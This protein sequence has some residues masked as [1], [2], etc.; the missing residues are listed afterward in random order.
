MI[1]KFD[2]YGQYEPYPYGCMF[3][4]NMTDKE[5]KEML[6]YGG[7]ETTYEQRQEL[8]AQCKKCFLKAAW[9]WAGKSE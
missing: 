7:F 8:R 4:L 2:C 6:E 9:E 3:Q 1:K 5:Y